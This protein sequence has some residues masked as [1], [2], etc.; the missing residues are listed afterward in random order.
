MLYIACDNSANDELR[1]TNLII[2]DLCA[3]N[4]LCWNNETTNNIEFSLRRKN[5]SRIKLSNF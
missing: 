4:Y 5:K 1:A 3:A 2:E